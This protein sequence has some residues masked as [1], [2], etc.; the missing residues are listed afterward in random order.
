MDSGSGLSRLAHYH[1][2][3]A[4]LL[5]RELKY[6][7]QA[8]LDRPTEHYLG[9][10]RWWTMT[11]GTMEQAREL[12][13]MTVHACMA[14]EEEWP[15]ELEKYTVADMDLADHTGEDPGP[16]EPAKIPLAVRAEPPVRVLRFAVA[17]AF[18][19]ASLLAGLMYRFAL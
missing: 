2:T 8:A 9:E 1:Q 19:L 7:V 10:L 3:V 16:D 17:V 6:D 18:S 11:E 15:Y 5:A 14:V 13:R 4:G 12:R